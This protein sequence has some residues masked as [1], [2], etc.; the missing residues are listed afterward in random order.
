MNITWIGHSCFLVHD[1]THT[2]LIDP[3]I[4]DNPAGA[5][6]PD[7]ARPDLILLTHGHFDH[8]GES[9][10]LS[11]QFEVPILCMPELAAYCRSQE[12]R[13]EIINYGG[14]YRLGNFTIKCVLAFHSSSAGPNRIY[15]GPPCGYVITSSDQTVYFAGD[16]CVFGDM[17]LIGE[18]FK[19][20]VAMLPIGGRT[21]MDPAEALMAVKW[22]R[23]R[24]VIPMHFN[25]WEFIRQDPQ[26]FKEAV[27]RETEAKVLLP[28]PGE[29]ITI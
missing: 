5:R 3:W 24:Y 8:L 15:A 14:S 9:V 28:A 1:G 26:A 13:A 7:N 19:L 18:L 20:D 17:K 27:E 11:K 29:N 22:L 12:A 2:L 4:R 16:T 10:E 23:P 6:L 21:T 25:T